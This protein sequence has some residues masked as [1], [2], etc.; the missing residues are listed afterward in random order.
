MENNF[1]THLRNEFSELEAAAV[2][3]EDLGSFC[4]LN[5]LI[6]GWSSGDGGRG[7]PLRI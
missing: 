6:R 2:K 1:F 7:F 4:W 3:L 5:L